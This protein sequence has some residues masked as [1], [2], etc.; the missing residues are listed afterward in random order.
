[1]HWLEE[2]AAADTQE[3]RLYSLISQPFLVARDL[4]FT[5]LFKMFAKMFA[6][7]N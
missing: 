1:M 2:N 7:F 6:T 4:V 3:R 5:I